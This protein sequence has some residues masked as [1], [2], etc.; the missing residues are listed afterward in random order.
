MKKR[1]DRKCSGCSLSL[2]HSTSTTHVRVVCLTA[3]HLAAIPSCK[4]NGDSNCLFP[5]H[6][7]QED[8]STGE[9]EAVPKARRLTL[10]F[11]TSNSLDG[12]SGREM[13]MSDNT[14]KVYEVFGCSHRP[15]AM[16]CP[17]DLVRSLVAAIV[18]YK[19]LCI[20]LMNAIY[21]LPTHHHQDGLPKSTASHPRRLPK[22]ECRYPHLL[23]LS[24]SLPPRRNLPHDCF[25]D[26]P[27]QRPQIHPLRCNLWLLHV[28]YSSKQRPHRLGCP[29]CKQWPRRR[30]PDPRQRRRRP[31]VY[32][33]PAL[34]PAHPPCDPAAHR[35]EQAGFLGLQGRL[36]P[37][38]PCHRHGHHRYHPELQYR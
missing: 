4:R 13:P 8:C 1:V 35:M 28:A 12:L 33:Q 29:P 34:R 24:R 9:H 38:C 31:P 14:M 27:S 37:H 23:R 7:C 36:H 21:L 18:T 17:S 3:S 16:Q 19:M 6:P 30:R 32:P 20:H 11:S 2:R 26:Q 5:S 15:A 10:L 22:G 25:P